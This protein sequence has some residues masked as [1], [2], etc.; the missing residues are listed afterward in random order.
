[1]EVPTVIL[2]VALSL[3]NTEDIVCVSLLGITVFIWKV[4]AIAKELAV[5]IRD[6]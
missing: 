3:H 2:G 6:A 5:Y 1:M 4:D